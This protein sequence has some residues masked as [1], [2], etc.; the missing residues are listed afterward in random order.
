MNKEFIRAIDELEKEKSISKD[1]L[2]EAIELALV[3]AY[4]KNY[5]TSQNVRVS[6]DREEGDIDVFMRKD[7]VEE[8]TDDFVEISLEDAMEI[9]DGGFLASLTS[10]SA[11]IADR[12]VLILDKFGPLYPLILTLLALCCI[13]GAILM[14]RLNKLGFH[15]YA[16]AQ[17]LMLLVPYVFGLTNFSNSFFVII[18]V[19]SV[20][21]TALFIWLYARELKISGTKN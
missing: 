21:I 19:L 7:V 13:I 17:V 11:A 3:S 8:V 12:M 14:L 2:I 20:L 5:G 15:L 4:K 6:I 1:V 9:A 18:Q 10:S 16:S